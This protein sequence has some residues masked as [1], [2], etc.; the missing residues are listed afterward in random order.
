MIEREVSKK[1]EVCSICLE[2]FGRKCT[3]DPD[4]IASCRSAMAFAAAAVVYF[5]ELRVTI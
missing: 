5:D 4:K 1:T 2:P 3:G